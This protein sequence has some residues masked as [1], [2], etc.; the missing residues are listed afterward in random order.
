MI[1]ISGGDLDKGVRCAEP[2]QT[3]VTE[4][5]PGEQI[6]RKS[7]RPEVAWR[8][9]ATE[10]SL[11]NRDFGSDHDEDVVGLEAFLRARRRDHIDPTHDGHDRAPDRL[12]LGETQARNADRG[13]I[14]ATVRGVDVVTSPIP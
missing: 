1:P 3:T 14:M 11:L 9:A 2:D 13:S 6:E 4:G 12:S 5:E 10:P 7:A 8:G